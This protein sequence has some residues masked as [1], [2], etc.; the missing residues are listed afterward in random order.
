MHPEP[1][2]TERMAKPKN[3]TG[4]VKRTVTIPYRPSN[5]FVSVLADSNVVTGRHD[6]IGSMIQI[7][8]TRL[9]SN[10]KTESFP[11]ET[12]DNVTKQSGLQNFSVEDVRTMMCSVSMRPDHVLG[13]ITSIVM[14]LMQMPPHLR[15]KYN[16]P[17]FEILMPPGQQ[18]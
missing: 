2:G 11:T 4:P 3:P 15:T 18:Q 6:E 12:L 5:H 13:L 10:I 14:Q 1:H 8:F 9:E 7:L 17:D 16:I